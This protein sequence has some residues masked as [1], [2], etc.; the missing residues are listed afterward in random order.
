MKRAILEHIDFDRISGL[1][2][3]FFR[4]T[5]FVTAIVSL[6]G[7][8]L[9][10]SGWRSICTR[11]HRSDDRTLLRCTQSDTVLSQAIR[12]GAPYHSYTCLNGLV[13]AA[14]PLVVDGEHVAN[15]FTGQVLLE[16]PDIDAFR[17]QAEEFGFE[18]SSYLEALAQVPVVAQEDLDTVMSFLSDMTHMISDI[19]CQEMTLI[20]A[21]TDLQAQE[22]ILRKSERK[23]R[24][25]FEA[26]PLGIT[27]SELSGKVLEKNDRA[28]ELFGVKDDGPEINLFTGEHLRRIRPDGTDLPDHE[29]AIMQAS[30]ESR[31]AENAEVGIVRPDASVSWV[32][33]SSFPHPLER[34]HVLSMYTDV[35]SKHRLEHDYR[36]LFTAMLNGFALQ[37]VI[38]D[39]SGKPYD[40]RFTDVNPAF[41][42]VWGVLKE[43]LIGM[44]A[45]EYFGESWRPIMDLYERVIESGKPGVLA[46]RSDVLQKQF[47]ITA[48]LTE[49]LHIFCLFRDV[50]ERQR[51]SR[52]L[53]KSYE[54]FR[55]AQDLSPDGFT[56][57]HPILDDGGR[58]VDFSWVYQNPAIA[59]INGTDPDDVIGKRL[60]EEFPS[61]RGTSVFEAYRQVAQ[62]GVAQTIE[63][64]SCED[65]LGKRLW[66]RLVIVPMS[67]DIAIL[68]QNLTERRQAEEL[69]SYQRNHDFLTEA[70][71]RV[72]L[73][74]KLRQLEK[75]NL[76]PVSIIMADTNG[77]KLINDSFG[78]S[79]GDAVL[80]KTAEFLT[81]LCRSDDFVVRYGGDE[82]AIVLPSTS[83]AESESRLKAL[84]ADTLKLE[85]DSMPFSLAFG[86]AARES[87]NDDFETVFKRAEDMMSRSKLYE[88]DSAKNKTIDLVMSSLFAKS[89]RES[90][91]SRRVSAICEFIGEELGMP[92]I[93]VSRLRI[94]GLMH[95]I[96][97]IGVEES[98]LNKPG[99]L[100]SDEWSHMTRHPEIG[101]RIL[102]AS[103]E[104]V[105]ISRN[106][107]EHHERWDGKGYPRGAVRGI[108]LPARQ[109]HYDC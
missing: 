14:I 99:K 7:E 67:E 32:Q 56:I 81:S 6:D 63:D 85:V 30:K 92:A 51:M 43:H 25:L 91:H 78:H 86:V 94:A 33:I 64:F 15:I 4:S 69:L 108:D 28:L 76:V 19:A 23:Y 103:N 66:L 62:S 88:S 8:V 49:S 93:E 60:L 27:V 9:S 24:M 13:D 5:G 44:T 46:Y 41:E 2:D 65:I 12:E 97:K 53:Q 80:K 107:L 100:S 3:G 40:Y 101:Y 35:T 55:I 48:F 45:R 82:F 17:A 104:F 47:E 31:Q 36:T 84:D 18:E 70:Y 106:I 11:F 1:L 109:N 71:S 50:T 52:N 26:F 20:E 105:D 75:A 98:I 42:Q 38:R 10:Q 39:P 21:N 89:P 22:T 87:V 29:C 61:H 95:D 77:L 73:E 34:A 54:R 16:P 57:L 68:T 96:G 79:E 58:V 74:E 59:R 90:E 72:F 102:S 37:E 83:L